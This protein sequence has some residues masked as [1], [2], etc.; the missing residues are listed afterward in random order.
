M[1]SLERQHHGR[2]RERAGRSVLKS[3]IGDGAMN[4]PDDMRRVEATLRAIGAI[5]TH[6]PSLVSQNTILDALRTVESRTN[7]VSQDTSVQNNNISPGSVSEIAFRRALARGR[8]PISHRAI[9]EIVSAHGPRTLIGNG[10]RRA[11]E[12]LNT[13]HSRLPGE[14]EASSFQRAVLPSVAPATS[15]TNGRLASILAGPGDHSELIQAIVTT[16]IEGGRQGF[17]DVRDLWT[18]LESID[19]DSAK[20]QAQRVEAGLSGLPLK[21]FR[22]LS[23]VQ[24]PNEGDFRDPDVS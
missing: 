9:A 13:V 5:S 14:G 3:T 22:K 8:F 20:R 10:M 16:I 23:L 18:R 12:K 11:R 2:P 1:G 17:A 15:Q 24:P 21:R 7:D 4:D 6:G 19:P